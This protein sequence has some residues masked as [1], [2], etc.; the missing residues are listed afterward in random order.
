MGTGN[1]IEPNN[2]LNEATGGTV[3]LDLWDKRNYQKSGKFLIG[4]KINIKKGG[5]K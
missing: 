2:F 1:I 5:R 3:I 4:K